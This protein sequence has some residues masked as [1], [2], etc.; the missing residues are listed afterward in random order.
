MKKK[1]LEVPSLWDSRLSIKAPEANEL[2]ICC[3]IMCDE[4]FELTD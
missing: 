3:P 2:F 4:Q 1:I